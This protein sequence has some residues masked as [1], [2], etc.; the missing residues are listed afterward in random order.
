MWK[1][2]LLVPVIL[3]PFQCQHLGLLY[4]AF[5]SGEGLKCDVYVVQHCFW[6]GYG[7]V[8]VHLWKRGSII[9]GL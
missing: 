1:G 4:L 6:D 5:S 8:G 7:Q 9:E 3:S 2:C